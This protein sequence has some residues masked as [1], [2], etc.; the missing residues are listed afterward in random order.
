MDFYHGE[1]DAYP[2]SQ[3]VDFEKAFFYIKLNLKSKKFSISPF[4]TQMWGLAAR[5]RIL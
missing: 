2:E 1:R 3:R 5:R 4:K